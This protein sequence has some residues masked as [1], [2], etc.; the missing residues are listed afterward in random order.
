MKVDGLRSCYD[1]VGGLVYFGRMLDKIRLHAAGKLPPE[2]HENLGTGFDG[3]CCHFLRV[4]YDE[5]V[6]RVKQGGTDEQML[7][8][9]FS[10]GRQPDD[11]EIEIWNGFMTKRGWRD[12]ASE[13]LAQRLKESGLT[14]RTDIHTMF[15]YIDADEGRSSHASF[16]SN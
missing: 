14:H 4:A 16:G 7:Q 10:R 5:L 9:C 15:D 1:Q 11:D 8:W 6:A 12:D 13:R 2:Y 3:R